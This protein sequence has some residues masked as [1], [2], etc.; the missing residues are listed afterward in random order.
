MAFDLTKRA[1]DSRTKTLH[2]FLLQS[3]VPSD[4]CWQQAVE[5]S[6][7]LLDDDV[8]GIVVDFC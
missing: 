8:T 5:F 7:N 6:P 3:T 4:L 1:M 2:T